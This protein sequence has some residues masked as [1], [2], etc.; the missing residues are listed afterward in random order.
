MTGDGGTFSLKHSLN[1]FKILDMQKIFLT[2]RKENDENG[3]YDNRFDKK[4]C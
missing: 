4:F 1:T 3:D 2:E